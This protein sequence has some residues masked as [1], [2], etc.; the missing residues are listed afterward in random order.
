[1]KPKILIATEIKNI[2]GLLDRFNSAFD[3]I[4]SPSLNPEAMD[5]LPGDIEY[6][7]TNPNN[8]QVYYGQELLSK[9][10][11][12]KCITTA[13]TGTIHID[14]DYCSKS[15][16]KIISITKSYDV[17][18]QI[19][20][21]AEM[22]FLLTMAALR[23]YDASR[24]A[25]DA[26]HWDYSNFIG[27]QMNCLTVGVVGF[28]RLG[29]I[30]ARYCRAFGANVLCCD[31]YKKEEV[32][33]DGYETGNIDELFE[34][35]DV[36]SLHVHA[37][38]SNLAL[39]NSA[40]LE[41]ISRPFVLVNTSRGEI[42]DEE[43]LLRVIEKNVYFK[44]ATDV[45]ENEHLG[46]TESRLRKSDRYGSQIFITPHCGGMT[47]DARFIAYN[48]AIDLLLQYLNRDL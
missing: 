24:R 32:L 16:V 42:V 40:F 35:C 1:M 25:V 9:F 11:D 7:F 21:T 45:I 34:V 48:H 44:Y 6:I 8:S 31:P 30:Y 47:S 29:K 41:D 14:K 13:S 39:V 19:S 26:M 2:T 28:G 15:G 3:V 5:A 4:Y 27:R 33:R 46:L 12:L 38:E 22:A 20:S 23:N 43:A 18:E 36:V 10:Q 17:L 37:T